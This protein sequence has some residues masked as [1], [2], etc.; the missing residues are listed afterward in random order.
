MK[1]ADELVAGRWG[2]DEEDSRNLFGWAEHID[3]AKGPMPQGRLAQNMLRRR[4]K[5]RG[6]I[7]AQKQWNK[8]KAKRRGECR[9]V[10]G[11]SMG[12]P[13]PLSIRPPSRGGRV[14]WGRWHLR[15]YP[16][17]PPLPFTF[18]HHLSSST[19]TV[20]HLASLMSGPPPG[21]NTDRPTGSFPSLAG[22]SVGG[23]RPKQHTE[24]YINMG[25]KIE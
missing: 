24:I 19:S 9:C 5:W 8:R 15:G 17:S 14:F 23:Q 2:G 7:C 18:C 6:G 22:N 12:C 20:A 25:T 21:P 3:E 16:P 13:P 11:T 4:G 10:H 1:R